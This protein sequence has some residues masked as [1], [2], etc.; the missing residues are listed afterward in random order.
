[1]AQRRMLVFTLMLIAIQA[2]SSFSH[3][4]YT[5]QTRAFQIQSPLHKLSSPKK[6]KNNSHPLLN[7]IQYDSISS[8][9]S[10]SLN[11]IRG[12]ASASFASSLSTK[13]PNAIYNTVFGGLLLSAV[14]FK[15]IQRISE[16]KSVASKDQDEVANTK[17][18]AVKGLQY[19]FL[20]V[21][22]LL[23]C[24]DWLQGPYFYDVYKSKVF[25]GVPATMG[26]ISKIFLAGFASTA[27]FGP[28]VGR[29][30]DT[31]GRKKGTLAFCVLY[32]LGALSTKSSL[33]TVLLL[34][35]L[36]N[37]I[38]TS[39]LFS[40]PEA[41]LVGETTQIPDGGSYLG[42]TFGLVRELLLLYQYKTYQIHNII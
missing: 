28:F 29:F 34:G 17:P 37:G 24:A 35:R 40:A 27:I 22:W 19:R 18:N 9:S 33:L 11:M 6:V 2:S 5:S 42:E 7:P 4:L 10:S 1:M 25:N 12:G 31:K 23:R 16:S 30:A 14:A 26:I 36:V 3:D 21:F 15:V 41:W 39:L 8:S 32:V 13:S 38:G 20:I